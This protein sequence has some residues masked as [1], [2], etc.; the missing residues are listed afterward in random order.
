MLSELEKEIIKIII[1]FDMFDYPLSA[2]EIWQYL[3]KKYSFQELCLVINQL[4]KIS[5]HQGLYF[6]NGRKEIIDIKKT[7]YNLAEKKFKRALMVSKFFRWLPWIQMI[8]VVNLIGA[9]NAKKEGDIDL[10]IITAP[11]KIWLTRLFS[12]GLLKIFGLRPTPHQV[13]DKICLSFFITADN[14]SFEPLLLNQ[15]LSNRDRYF[16]Y[17][18]ANLYP[19]Y[20]KN[21]TYQELIKENTW[22]RNY[23]PNWRPKTT[24]EQRGVLEIENNLYNKI[25]D[26]LLSSFN[27]LAKKLQM[28]V[29]AKE[30]KTIM[31][32]GTEVVINDQ[33]LKLHTADA[34]Q[35]YYEQYLEKLNLILNI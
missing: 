3:P 32:Q 22:L 4:E 9:H 30:L 14:L 29:M 15:S 24:S 28:I 16:T 26:I 27:G 11:K 8:A 18:L 13:Q 5:C 12:V 21:N 10:L 19:I 23:L 25:S 7:R 35:K 2:L 17:W 31:N 34:R 1:Y 33:I 20:N 6:L